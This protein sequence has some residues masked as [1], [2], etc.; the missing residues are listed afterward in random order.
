MSIAAFSTQNI[1]AFFLA[2]QL[3][4]CAKRRR[5]K[6]YVLGPGLAVGQVQIN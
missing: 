3:G 6:R 1:R 5:S 4:Q 2:R